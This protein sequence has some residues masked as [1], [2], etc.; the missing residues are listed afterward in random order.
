MSV[1]IKLSRRKQTVLMLLLL[2]FGVGLLI[3]PDIANWY[4]S[5]RHAAILQ[6]Y[7]EEVARMEAANIEYELDRAIA[8]NNAL[9]G[10]EA[11]DPFAPGSGSVL[12]MEYYHILNLEG[13]MGRIEIP[14]ID[15]DLPI[16]HGTSDDVLD[17]G[18]GHMEHTPFPIGG[19]G[20]HSVLSAHAGLVNSRLFTDLELLDIGDIFIVTVLTNRIAFEVD[21]IDIIL[22]DQID[23]LVSYDDRD[24]I[25]LV[26]CTPYGINSHRLLVRGTRI[27]YV[28]NMADEIIDITSPINVRLIII[29]GFA[30]L[31]AVIFFVYR[32][33][34]DNEQL[35]SDKAELE[36]EYEAWLKDEDSS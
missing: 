16:F 30:F 31:F 7:T 21:R 32:R 22:P 23:I 4:Q 15:V 25:T 27:D 14:A 10:I 13:T 35:S 33:K 9:G 29:I 26:T 19:Y 24:L 2:V 12:S 8:H 1:K 18:V 5:R 17:R 3:Y 34:K 36:R 11:V 20:N 28:E 6:G